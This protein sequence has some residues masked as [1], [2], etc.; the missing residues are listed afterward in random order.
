MKGERE[1]NENTKDSD[2]RKGEHK[3]WNVTPIEPYI[4]P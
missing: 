3:K 2:V 4:S 1:K